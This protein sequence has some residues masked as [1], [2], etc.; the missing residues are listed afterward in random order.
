ML[1][2]VSMTWTY[3][4]PLFLFQNCHILNEVLLFPLCHHLNLFEPIQI[5]GCNLRMHPVAVVGHNIFLF[6]HHYVQC[7]ERITKVNAE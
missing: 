2:R 5:Q 7:A 6:S 3:V 4:V 1:E